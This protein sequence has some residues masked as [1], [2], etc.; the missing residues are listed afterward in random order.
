MLQ[1]IVGTR[2]TIDPRLCQAKTAQIRVRAV[3]GRVDLSHNADLAL[4]R[5]DLIASSGNFDGR[6]WC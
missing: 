3:L 6:S 4:I 5:S 1:P 2:E